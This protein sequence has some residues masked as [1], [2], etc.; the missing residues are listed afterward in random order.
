MLLDQLY[1]EPRLSAKFL[2]KDLGDCHTDC[3]KEAHKLV[4]DCVWMIQ[5]AQDF[6]LGE[7]TEVIRMQEMGS[8]F[9]RQ[10]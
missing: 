8:S 2:H 4:G 10:E 3:S 7:R 9:E 1:V 6:A 5:Q